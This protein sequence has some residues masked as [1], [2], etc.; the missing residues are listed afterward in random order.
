MYFLRKKI[1][2]NL[3]FFQYHAPLSRSDVIL[4]LKL[5]MNFVQCNVG[6]TTMTF[7]GVSLQE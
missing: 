3:K 5:Q 2:E 6:P 7:L 1:A 4:P